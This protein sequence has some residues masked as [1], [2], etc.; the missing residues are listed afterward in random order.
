MLN[1]LIYPSSWTLRGLEGHRCRNIVRMEFEGLQ[2]HLTVNEGLQHPTSPVVV[3]MPQFLPPPSFCFLYKIYWVSEERDGWLIESVRS[4]MWYG[5]QTSLDHHLRI[6]Y[7]LFCLHCTLRFVSSFLHNR[8]IIPPL[9]NCRTTL[10]INGTW[11]L[12]LCFILSLLLLLVT[13]NLK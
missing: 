5:N 12:D 13:F 6:V 7:I 11:P 4:W 3:C 2:H 1:N 9:I 10:L 8:V